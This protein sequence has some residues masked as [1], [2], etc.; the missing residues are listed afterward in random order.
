MQ[1]AA[2][3]HLEEAHP[4]DSYFL[5]HDLELLGLDL[6]F[7]F[8]FRLIFVEIGEWFEVEE[9]SFARRL[10]IGSHLDSM[11]VLLL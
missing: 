10:G 1:E 9:G 8:C 3:L 7:G 5:Y 6:C 2:L 4:F 11:T